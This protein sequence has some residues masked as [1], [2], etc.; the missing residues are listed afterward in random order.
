[1]K[2]TAVRFIGPAKVMEID[3]GKVVDMVAGS[4]C[5][6]EDVVHHDRDYFVFKDRRIGVT[7]NHW[8]EL[9]RFKI[10]ELVRMPTAD[11]PTYDGIPLPLTSSSQ[12][13]DIKAPW[14]IA[15]LC[16]GKLVCPKCARKYCF[17]YPNSIP[18]YPTNILPRDQDCHDCGQMLVKVSKLGDNI[19][20]KKY[21]KPKAK[22]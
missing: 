22:R 2:I 6:L 18:V 15:H 12:I 10:V 9:E 13:K 17:A 3:T 11:D 19:L 20:F 5:E 1:M 8:C 4:Y 21:V 16:D 7:V 14:P